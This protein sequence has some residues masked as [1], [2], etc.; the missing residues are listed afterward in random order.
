MSP[1]SRGPQ[2]RAD[3]HV[4]CVTRASSTSRRPVLAVCSWH[5][6]RNMSPELETCCRA[7][8]SL[9]QLP[10]PKPTSP[11]LYYQTICCQKCRSC[12]SHGRRMKR[13]QH[14]NLRHLSACCLLC[15]PACRPSDAGRRCTDAWRSQTTDRHI[16]VNYTYQTLR[17]MR[18]MVATKEW[19]LYY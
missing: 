8:L 6:F 17:F 3:S 9:L 16:Q 15:W 5:I 7:L 1:Q 2:R 12:S 10:M 14:G 19:L 13:G 18:R 4:S 11:A